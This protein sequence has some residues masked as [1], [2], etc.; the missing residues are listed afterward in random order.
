MEFAVEVTKDWKSIPVL[1]LFIYSV[2]HF[3][4][5]HML[6]LIKN[7]IWPYFSCIFLLIFNKQNIIDI[8][9][10]MSHHEECK[11]LQFKDF[12]ISI[13]KM[14]LSLQSEYFSLFV[15]LYWVVW[16]RVLVNA[17]NKCFKIWMSNFCQMGKDILRISGDSCYVH[18]LLLLT[19]I[20]Q[21][22]YSSVSYT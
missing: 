17:L 13:S 20:I 1:I 14:F 2:K 3:W 22:L 21:C 4:E 10:T 7:D 9:Y 8:W 5:V 16:R 19:Y 18:T 11:S 6:N 12:K 15:L